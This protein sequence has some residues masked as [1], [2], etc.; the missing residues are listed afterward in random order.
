MINDVLEILEVGKFNLKSMKVNRTHKYGAGDSEGR[1]T[2]FSS[3]QHI[4]SI[5]STSF[6]EYGYNNTLY[7]FNP[8]KV[9]LKVY[10]S[11]WDSTMERSGDYIYVLTETIHD[12]KHS[13]PIN[14]ERKDTLDTHYFFTSPKPSTKKYIKVKTGKENLIFWNH[15]YFETWKMTYEGN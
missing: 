11:I 10:E 2:E 8:K 1:I 5:D 12:F 4:I 15:R 6:G 9:L 7:V 13:K 14:L 3:E